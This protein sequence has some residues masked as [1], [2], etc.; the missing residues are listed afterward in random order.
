MD[1]GTDLLFLDSETGGILTS[2]PVEKPKRYLASPITALFVF[3]SE[4][5]H[6]LDLPAG[7]KH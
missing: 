6:L 7:V 5:L 3:K 2:Q 4:T 1:A